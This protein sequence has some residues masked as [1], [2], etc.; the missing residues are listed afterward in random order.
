[1]DLKI[2]SKEEL[3]NQIEWFLKFS[4][5]SEKEKNE[6]IKALWLSETD[7]KWF[8]N[9]FV[10]FCS[11]EVDISDKK[12]IEKRLKK[13]NIDFEK[14]WD[15]YQIYLK[16]KS[17]EKHPQAKRKRVESFFEP[18][19]TE[20]TLLNERLVNAIN[21]VYSKENM[22]KVKVFMSS[23][24]Y[25]ESYKKGQTKNTAF[26]EYFLEN[27][28][29]N[30]D[31]QFLLDKVSIDDL[32]IFFS[33]RILLSKS[34]IEIV[35]LAVNEFNIKSLVQTLN[36]NVRLV[37]GP[38]GDNKNF[39][40]SSD[41]A[42][43]LNILQK[44]VDTLKEHWYNLKQI[45][46]IN[47]LLLK[48][49]SFYIEKVNDVVSFLS[50]YRAEA[51]NDVY[52]W[53]ADIKNKTKEELLSTYIKY[54]ESKINEFLLIP[55][56]RSNEIGF[57][58]S[59]VLMDKEHFGRITK[60]TE[61]TIHYIFSCDTDWKVLSAMRTV[62]WLKNWKQNINLAYDEHF[63]SSKHI[64]NNEYILWL[65]CI[66]HWMLKQLVN[67]SLNWILKL[68][69]NKNLFE[70]SLWLIIG[71]N[72]AHGLLDKWLNKD[73]FKKIMWLVADRN[74]TYILMKRILRPLRSEVKM[75]RILRPLR[76]E[77]KKI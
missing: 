59:W 77:V 8:F 52:K 42:N 41:V 9:W 57:D 70:L 32:Q 37:K 76:S 2:K 56:K 51:E 23:P 54:D 50:D 73:N 75:K 24:V 20:N 45:T 66:P 36:L 63:I 40:Y 27:V 26:L 46:N 55:P 5:F 35:K 18:Y 43:N 10:K 15:S 39:W 67:R 25:K 64:S 30:E 19:K 34:F 61:K 72:N 44:N 11:K 69:L 7:K 31:L 48:D 53:F 17:I 3:I 38:L 49:I 6:L 71:T 33:N 12:E 14:L 60:S 13:K 29:S 1:M 22:G 16:E 47:K 65:K 74:N 4:Q 58:I 68:W 21:N 28:K 62:K